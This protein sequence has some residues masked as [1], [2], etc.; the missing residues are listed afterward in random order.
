[1]SRSL[2]SLTEIDDPWQASSIGIKCINYKPIGSV[3]LT[4][5]VLDLYETDGKRKVDIIYSYS[6]K[7]NSIH[8]IPSRGTSIENCSFCDTITLDFDPDS[9][10]FDLV[11]EVQIITQGASNKREE[12]KSELK[13][14]TKKKVKIKTSE[15]DYEAETILKSSYDLSFTKGESKTNNHS[16]S[17]NNIY[18]IPDNECESKIVIKTIIK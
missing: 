1:M 2:C 7:A 11:M 10:L 18:K 5:R 13:E 9:T 4:R 15:D 12:S 6:K 14:T 17:E 16:K 8:K 3:F